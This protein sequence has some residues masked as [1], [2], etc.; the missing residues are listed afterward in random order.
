MSNVKLA[1]KIA[2][3]KLPNRDKPYFASLSGTGIQ[4][5]YR[6]GS[7]TWLVRWWV[8]GREVQRS[9][10]CRADDL[11]PADGARIMSFRQAAMAALERI[12]EDSDVQLERLTV[13]Q[14]FERYTKSRD[15]VGRDTWDSW[16]R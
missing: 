14:V 7:R 12:G 5:G 13:G 4:L 15:A 8:D 11:F 6:T 1:S 10:K 3:Q 16:I 9:L 2:R